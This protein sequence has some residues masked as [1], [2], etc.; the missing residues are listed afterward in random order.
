MS[1]S[2]TLSAMAFDSNGFHFSE[3]YRN[4]NNTGIYMPKISWLVMY[5]LDSVV[6]S[7]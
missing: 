7:G 2:R 1:L 6:M 4:V 3:V 5:L